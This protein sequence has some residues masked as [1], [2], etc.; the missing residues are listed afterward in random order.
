MCMLCMIMVVM[1][2]MVVVTASSSL[3]PLSPAPSA[4]STLFDPL[5]DQVQRGEEQYQVQPE[6]LQED[7]GIWYPAPDFGGGG[8][9]PIPH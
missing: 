3:L 2:P 4:T 9:A 8:T 5:E 6:I 1:M 7:Y